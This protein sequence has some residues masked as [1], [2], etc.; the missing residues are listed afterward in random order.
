[1][2]TKGFTLIETL[3]VVF[4]IGVMATVAIQSYV[5]ST[6]TFKFLSSYQQVTSALRT[7]RSNA[8]SN[9]LQSGV[10]VKRY[11]VCIGANGIL[12][13]ADTGSKDFKADFTS[14]ANINY[15]GGS[16]YGCSFTTNANGLAEDV[17]L[18]DKSFNISNSGYLAYTLDPTIVGNNNII[19]GPVVIF[20]DSGTGNLTAK[21]GSGNTISK[22]TIPYLSIQFCQNAGGGTC[23]ATGQTRYIKVYQV[24]GLAEESTTK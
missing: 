9:E 23:L 12:T 24:S 13:F 10:S 18:Q 2:K 3:L 4:L 5:G 15:M 19:T 8:L 11:G 7:A 14:Q 22:S 1:M 16:G 6:K 21:D 17:I 20:Y